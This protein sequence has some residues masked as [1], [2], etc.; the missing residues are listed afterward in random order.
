MKESNATLS[1][2]ERL[3][4][5]LPAVWDRAQVV[6]KWVWLEFNVVPDKEIRENLKKLGFHWNHIRRCWQHSCG[7]PCGHSKD[8][9]R[10]RYEVKSTSELAMN[11]APTAKEYKIIA[12]RECPLP[13]DMQ[14][15]ER[16]EQCADYW[17]MNIATNPYFNPDCECLAVLMLNTRHRVKGHQLVTI[18]TMNTLLV[19][20]REVFRG[21]IIA[22]AHAIVMMHNHPSGEPS[23]SDADIKV[24]RDLIRAGQLVNI[25]VLDHVII[26]NQKHSS[27]RG[28]GYFYN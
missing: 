20:P 10:G 25:D 14:Y 19:H 5:E 7:V 17:R 27:L 22:G 6:G 12:L 8:D 4:A 28:L 2:L 11:D 3:K 9:P 26:G 24:T 23:P 13:E 21:A 15:C 1:L 18:G 16:P